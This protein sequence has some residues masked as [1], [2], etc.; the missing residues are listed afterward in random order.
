MLGRNEVARR[1]GVKSA[2]MVTQSKSW[3]SIANEFGLGRTGRCLIKSGFA[4]IEEQAAVAAGDSTK[5][6]VIQR[7][8]QRLIEQAIVEAKT[9]VTKEGLREMQ[10]KLKGGETNDNIVR[11][12]IHLALKQEKDSLAGEALRDRP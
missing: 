1:L 9:E 7:E 5:K 10:D 8:T 4:M 2:M 12:T 11:D 6:E 3:R